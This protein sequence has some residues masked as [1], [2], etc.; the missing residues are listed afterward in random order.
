MESCFNDPLNYFSRIFDRCTPQFSRCDSGIDFA[1]C[2]TP[3]LHGW[4]FLYSDSPQCFAFI[5]AAAQQYWLEILMESFDTA[6][7]NV[8]YI[9]I[10]NNI[11]G[12]QNFHHVWRAWALS[13]SYSISHCH[14]VLILAK[15]RSALVSASNRHCQ[16]AQLPFPENADKRMLIRISGI[17]F[18][19]LSSL[20]NV[21]VVCEATVLILFENLSPHFSCG[22]SFLILL[23]WNYGWIA[24]F[25]FYL[26]CIPQ[27]LITNH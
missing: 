19:V 13:H 27:C 20:Q 9:V 16:V 2:Q 25:V 6:G 17:N 1:Q 24:L 26:W 22:L 18:T 4:E 21:N 12:R 7:E 10:L 15:H 3:S 23:F 8:Q 5:S 11:K 14:L